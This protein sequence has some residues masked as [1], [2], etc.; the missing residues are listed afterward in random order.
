[1][2]KTKLL[3]YTT[4]DFPS[5]A[6]MNLYI[7]Y[8]EQ[9]ENDKSNSEKLLNAG[10]VRRTHS[11]IWNSNNVFRIGI[12]FEYKDEKCFSKVQKLLSEFMNNTETKELLINTKMLWFL[13]IFF[14]F[15]RTFGGKLVIEFFSIFQL[16]S[17]GF[18]L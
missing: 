6:Q 15:L 8:I 5:K 4:I 3:S 14:I 12:T 7:K 9:I 11:Q 1:M 18:S 16:S 10:L 17:N 13:H 2:Q